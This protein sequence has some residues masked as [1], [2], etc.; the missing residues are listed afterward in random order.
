MR[1]FALVASLILYAGSACAT[2]IFVLGVLTEKALLVVDGG[3]PKIY[4]VGSKIGDNAKLLEVSRT[5]ATI[6][7][8]GKKFVI[9]LGQYAPRLPRAAG[10][11]T[12]PVDSGGHYV[13]SGKING[14]DA[15]MMIDTGATFISMSAS[16]ARRFG[17]E[18]RLGK[19]H[20]THTAN[21]AARVVEAHV[22]SIRIGDIEVKDFEVMISQDGALPIILLGNNFLNRFEMTRDGRQMTLTAH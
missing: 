19:Q 16:D 1:Y 5:G 10:S 3:A 20:M 14:I 22:D 7:E 11:V 15:R 9:A 12:L 17:I 13:V 8:G 2:D 18:T 6:E 21:G 4:A